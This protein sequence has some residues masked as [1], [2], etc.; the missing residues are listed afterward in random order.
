[1]DKIS[2]YVKW[3]LVG[4]LY[5]ILLTPILITSKYVFPF[6]TGK[7]MFFR[8][9]V[10][11]ALLVYIILAILN[12]K[13][14]PKMNKLIWAV[15]IFGVIVG[16]TGFLGVDAY[17]SF[18]GTIERGEGFLTISHLVI[19][20]LILSW[21]LKTKGEWLSYLTGLVVVGL[22]VDLYAILQ[23]AEFQ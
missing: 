19:F 22:L 16:L 9:L 12:K 21:T 6:I 13:Y 10:E 23:R 7:T 8:I 5:L 20:F 2:K 11:V 1:M 3:I 17:K 15:V 4:I 18:W 14:R